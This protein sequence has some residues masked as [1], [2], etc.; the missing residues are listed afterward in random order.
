MSSVSSIWT[1]STY[2][3]FVGVT[4]TSHK[5]VYLLSH[6]RCDYASLLA[7]VH[8]KFGKSGEPECVWLERD[9]TRFVLALDLWNDYSSAIEGNKIEFQFPTNTNN[10]AIT[11]DE[12]VHPP[13]GL[14]LHFNAPPTVSDLGPL[15]V[16]LFYRDQN[17]WEDIQAKILQSAHLPSSPI[18]NLEVKAPFPTWWSDQFGRVIVTVVNA[19]NW[20]HIVG[21]ASGCAPDRVTDLFLEITEYEVSGW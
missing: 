10:N 17:S 8:R 13:G 2:P 19:T 1:T 3:T 14:V 7:F 11:K 21:A 12:I 9:G 5:E 16:R 6:R 4:V 20:E 18:L 15:D